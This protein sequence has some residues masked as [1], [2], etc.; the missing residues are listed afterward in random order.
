MT[1]MLFF[2]FFSF[3]LWRGKCGWSTHHDYQNEI[4]TKKDWK[5]F[6]HSFTH[7]HEIYWTYGLRAT[8]G[9]KC[10][11]QQRICYIFSVIFYLLLLSISCEAS[12]ICWGL[13]HDHIFF[14]LSAGLKMF[15]TS[16][17]YKNNKKKCLSS[18][19]PNQFASSACEL[20]CTRRCVRC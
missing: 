17:C 15:W 19:S 12:D 11:Q 10:W 6:P 14:I 18:F 7:M 20:T 8:F 5:K 4:A 9:A 1:S 16:K 2:I 3:P 13:P